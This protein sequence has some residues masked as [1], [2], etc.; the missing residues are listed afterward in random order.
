MSPATGGPARP[1][2]LVV[3]DTPANLALLASVLKEKG[4]RVRPV[5]SGALALKAA[6][7]EPPDLVLL[8]INMPVMNGFEVCAELK[9]DE[10]LRD[11]P[12][13]F[14]SALTETLDK[15]KA[16]AC[17]GVD[18]VT[19]PF[20][21]EEVDARVSCH[22]TL[23]RLRLEAE[24]HARELEDTNA[25]LREAERQ[26]EALTQ[27][28]VHDLKNPL[29]AALANT[30]FILDEAGLA[31]EPRE[32]AES[33]QRAC[34]RMYRM[35]LDVLD[36]ARGAGGG[37]A[38]RGEPVDLHA[39]VA[40]V[41]SELR[42][43]PGRLLVSAV[44]PDVGLLVADRDLLVRVLENLI[45]NSLKYAPPGTD[46]RIEAQA[47][48]AGPITIRVCDQGPGIPVE[49][50]ERIFEPYT[51]LAADAAKHARTSRGLGLAFCRLAV[52]AHGGR[53]WVEDNQPVG[54]AF[55][56]LLPRA[57]PAAPAPATVPT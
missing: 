36:V 9:R 12:V 14:L 7:S 25:R 29:S 2:I 48:P 21:V 11:I 8:D 22:L 50:R 39:L 6:R 17:G 27:M 10:R 40:E 44:P 49:G 5:T 46:V 56:V 16:F 15:I 32:A 43:A 57:G 41:V 45:D 55:C 47:T 38:V 18:Y 26:R 51:R 31:G 23:R 33:T 3:D 20:Q 37:L 13:I 30:E 34:E 4:Y 19:K 28:I 35:V 54:T 53:I 42:P 24:Q 52:L 1:S